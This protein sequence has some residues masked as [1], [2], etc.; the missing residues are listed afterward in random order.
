MGPI[1][2]SS[3]KNPRTSDVR[4][5]APAEPMGDDIFYLRIR[6][7]SWDPDTYRFGDVSAFAICSQVFPHGERYLLA[8]ANDHK[9]ILGVDIL[10]YH[11][12]VAQ[13]GN[14]YNGYLP[15]HSNYLEIEEGVEKRRVIQ[16]LLFLKLSQGAGVGE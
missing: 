14:L 15:I 2:L 1:D 3:S 5:S 6:S 9:A 11:H 8:L 13:I 7:F 4:R 16:A 12:R 10:P